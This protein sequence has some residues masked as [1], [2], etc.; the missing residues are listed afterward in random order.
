MER[1][2]A[3]KEIFESKPEGRS[4]MGRR[5]FRWLKDVVRDLPKVKSKRW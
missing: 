4:R 1:G 5:K 3:D 2:R